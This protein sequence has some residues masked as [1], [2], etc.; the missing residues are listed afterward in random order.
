M[1]EISHQEAAT[2][3]ATFITGY[4]VAGFPTK[5]S[6]IAIIEQAVRAGV[7]VIELGFPSPK[8]YM[9]GET[10]Q[11]AHAQALGAFT[12]LADF[13]AYM[14]ELRTKV[15]VPIWIMGYQADLLSEEKYLTLAQSSMVDRF[16]IPDITMEQVDD[17]QKKLQQENVQLVP[18]I[19]NNMTDE[20]IISRT[21]T[22]DIVYC[23]L[24]AGKTGGAFTNHTAL[25]AFYKRMRKI[26]DA[27]LMAG[28][29]IKNRRLANDIFQVGYDGIVIGSA[30]MRL[31]TLEQ[32]TKLYELI[33]QLVK[34]KEKWDDI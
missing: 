9:D 22:T 3:P 7:N 5:E 21:K 13:S 2:I 6:S 15:S 34:I 11:K 14:Q 18:V 32:E 19:N 24:Y 10:I 16:V 17:I 23:Q 4:F 25:R 29:G 26:T 12:S 28:F 1:G 20:A 30:F 27:K 31:V 8:P 33:Q